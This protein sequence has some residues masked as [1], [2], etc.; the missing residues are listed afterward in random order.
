MTVAIVEE[1][2]APIRVRAQRVPSSRIGS[3]IDGELLAMWTFLGVMAI[4]A[5]LEIIYLNRGER[6]PKAPGRS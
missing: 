3:A 6:A 4:G 2:D 1:P 5:I